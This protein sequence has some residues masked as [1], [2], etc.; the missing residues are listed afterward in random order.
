[1]ESTT[2]QIRKEVSKST[3]EV[4]RV[5]KSDYQK[6]GTLTAELRQ[7]VTTKSYYPSKSV[8]NDHQDNIFSAAEFSFEE[9]EYENIET[10]VA[11]IDVPVGS[12]VESVTAKL[13]N[14]K[15]ATLYKIMANAPILTDS[16]KYAIDNGITSIDVFANRQAVR[17][18]DGNDKAGQLAL[19]ANG[20][21]QY[22][23]VFF[24][25]SA[26]ADMDK[27]GADATIYLSAELEAE[28]NNV[29]AEVISGQEV[30]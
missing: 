27:R 26:I 11:W 13:A 17:F 23:S 1:M 18:P 29:G 22:R 30:M 24:M 8:S 16:Q 19:D 2:N 28:V 7:T 15:E 4:S 10:R 21:V 14:F 20:N 5:Y 12:T 25:S 6:E 9:K 3:L